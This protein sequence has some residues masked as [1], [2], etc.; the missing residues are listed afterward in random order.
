MPFVLQILLA[1]M[2]RS[3]TNADEHLR[4]RH[5]SLYLSL[6][7]SAYFVQYRKF[8]A[9]IDIPH[10]GQLDALRMGWNRRRGHREQSAASRALSGTQFSCIVPGRF[11]SYRYEAISCIAALRT[12]KLGVCLLRYVVSYPCIQLSLSTK[13]RA[14]KRRCPSSAPCC[15]R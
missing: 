8:N 2:Q 11:R 3:G 5:P 4:V 12:I 1:Y 9:A 10:A 13:R 15:R 6:S 7:L 14:S